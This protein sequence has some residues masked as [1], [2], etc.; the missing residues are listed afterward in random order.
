[1]AGSHILAVM[2]AAIA[3]TILAEKRG[4]QP[5][6]LLAAVGVLASFIPGL[7]RAELAPHVILGLVLPPLLYSA[8]VDF[9][10]ASFIRRI[11]SI[12]N[13][14]VVLVV[15]TTAAA[16]FALGWALPALSLPI[17]FILGAV[18]APPDAVSAVSIGRKL[19][20]PRRLMTI[21]K[22][23]SLINDAAALTLFS[24]AVA[25]ATG[26]HSFIDSVALYFLYAAG[27]G[28]AVGIVLGLVVHRIR[29]RLE[30]PTLITALAIIV[31]FAAYGLA[32]ELHASGVMAV[33]FAG[34]TL[35]HNATDLAFAGRIQERE[36]WRVI[37][38]LLE[39]FAF[40]YMGL[41]LPFAIEA[42]RASGF[43]LAKVSLA[44]ILVLAVV[45]GTRIA[46]VMATALLARA[47]HRLLAR[48]LARRGKEPRTAPLSWRENLVLSWTGMRGVVTLAAAAGTPLLTAA[49]EPLVGREI[50]LPV[51]FTVAIG[52]L[53]LQGMTL[54]WLIGRLALGDPREADYARAQMAH[55]RRVIDATTVSVIAELRE[56]ASP[57]T[58]IRLA[59]QMLR[60]ARRAAEE[61][62][63][64]LPA[65]SAPRRADH[66]DKIL[67]IARSVLAEQRQA[68]IAERDADRLD[69]EVLREVL[70]DID[71]E[72]AVIARRSERLAER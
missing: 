55:A 58:D 53:L 21:L 26:R 14:G 13:L 9:S 18:V 32:E 11:G 2:I 43:D 36:V 19:G 8:A 6:L 66:R 61:H 27:L 22:G 62:D 48:K 24:V 30:N 17:A 65:G 38:A 44:A 10:F 52:T 57:E 35:G 15:V 63:G 39:A 60:R 25:A 47:R 64:D 68:L 41:Q 42:A 1:M 45:I 33:V 72:Q 51:A 70:E 4:I 5:P 12:L 40:A 29:K 34:F 23:E 28:T 16:G 46:W 54:P 20:L 50:I 31:P 69:D 7:P 67:A 49:G 59:T 56:K 71:L 3:L 37:D